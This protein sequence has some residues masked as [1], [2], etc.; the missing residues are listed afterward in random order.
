[1][2]TVEQSWDVVQADEHRARAAAELER[3][4]VQYEMAKMMR[5]ERTGHTYPTHWRQAALRAGATTW[6]TAE[7]LADLAERLWEVMLAYQVL[8]PDP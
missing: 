2:K 8:G 4:F 3:V 1:M 5:W 7:E 6:P